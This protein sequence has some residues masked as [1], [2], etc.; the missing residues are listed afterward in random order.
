M[1][2]DIA[3][4]LDKYLGCIVGAAAGDALEMCIRDSI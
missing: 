4:T 3:R 1:E 2:I